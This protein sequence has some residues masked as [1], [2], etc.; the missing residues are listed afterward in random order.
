MHVHRAVAAHE[1]SRRRLIILFYLIFRDWQPGKATGRIRQ[2]RITGFVWLEDILDKVWHKHGVQPEE[3]TEIFDSTARYRFVER[4]HRAG[5]DVYAA[6]G[7]TSSGRYWIVFLFRKKDGR[8]LVVS[9]RDMTTAERK[10]Y[11]RK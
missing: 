8:A 9:A 1:Q 2:V 11:E 10:R 5:E 3:V 7:Q 6:L 4:G